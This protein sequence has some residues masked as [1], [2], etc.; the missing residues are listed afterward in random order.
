M[1]LCSLDQARSRVV[2]KNLLEF[3]EEVSPNRL[4]GIV[5]R[6]YPSL[7][8]LAEFDDK[9]DAA[10][11]KKAKQAQKCSKKQIFRFLPRKITMNSN[12][13]GLSATARQQL[14]GMWTALK[15]PCQ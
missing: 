14:F 1:R 2:D 11:L 4:K 15:K 3:I 8:L 5:E 9:K 6:P 13:C 12:V 7:I 10:Q